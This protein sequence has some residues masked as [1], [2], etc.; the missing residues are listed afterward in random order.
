MVYLQGSW[1]CK[2]D[3]F[4]KNALKRYTPIMLYVLGRRHAESEP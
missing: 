3:S 4:K 2:N 1:E